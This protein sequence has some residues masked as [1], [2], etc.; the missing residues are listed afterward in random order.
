M[1]M[2]DMAGVKANTMRLQRKSQRAQKC[3]SGT[4]P[5][6]FLGKKC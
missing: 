2:P 4:L 5:R 6:A 1:R 3:Q